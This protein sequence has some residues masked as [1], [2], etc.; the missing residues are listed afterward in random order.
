MLG[1]SRYSIIITL[2]H[3]CSL[4]NVTSQIIKVKALMLLSPILINTKMKSWNVLQGYGL[5]SFTTLLSPL[6]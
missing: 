4:Y 2:Q 1:Q 3:W 6:I 5:V